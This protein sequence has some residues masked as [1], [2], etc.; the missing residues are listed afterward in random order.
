MKSSAGWFGV[1]RAIVALA[2][3]VLVV[4]CSQTSPEPAPEFTLPISQVSATP[5]IP[6]EASAA[7]TTAPRRLRYIAVPPG[8]KVAGMA[9]ARIVLKQGKRKAH[10]LGHTHKKT[11]APAA[12]MKPTNRPQSRRF[13]A[14]GDVE[15]GPGKGEVD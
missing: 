14:P 15:R 6:G 1:F 7:E 3:G 2:C 13:L 5:P 4:A 10:H 9:H 8:E 12:A 11:V